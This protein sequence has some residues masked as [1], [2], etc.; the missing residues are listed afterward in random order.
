MRYLVW[1]Y[2]GFRNLG[3]ELMLEE[4]VRRIRARDPGAEIN[5]RCYEAPNVPGTIAF[6][7]ENFGTR[8]K[9]AAAAKYV[10]RILDITRR[11]DYLVIGGGTLFL[12]RGRHNSSMALL[13]LTVAVAVWRGVRV[14]TVGLGIDVITRP[15]NRF[16]LKYILQAS[17]VVCVRDD[18]SV[19]V[20]RHLVAPERVRRAGDIV[21]AIRDLAA[22]A[23]PQMSRP[24]AVIALVD[25]YNTVAPSAEK[26]SLFMNRCCELARTILMQNPNLDIRFCAFQRQIGDR[27]DVLLEEVTALIG[28]HTPEL[29]KR[30]SLCRME[31]RQEIA[32]VYAAA[33]FTVTMRYHA[34][35]LSAM[36][37]RPFLAIEIEMKLRELSR[38]FGM[39]S[40]PIDEFMEAGLSAA[41]VDG[42][43][44]LVIQPEVLA[45]QADMAQINFDW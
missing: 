4:I 21:F 25:V 34:A 2:Y 41:Q 20:A 36:F 44:R 42:L 9:L 33:S 22:E 13:A 10:R 14:R 15:L 11:I 31:T 39:P 40:L 38:E 8:S 37:G 27:D 30:V 43:R 32:E 24:V 16:Y 18:F 35:V 19:L 17:E 1:G 45:R 6:P 26:R 3:D 5:V 23:I 29:R 7:I 12:D 28:R